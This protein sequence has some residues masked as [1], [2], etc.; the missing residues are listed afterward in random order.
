MNLYVYSDESGV[1]DKDHNKYYVF[2]GLICATKEKRDEYARLYLN[3]EKAAMLIDGIKDDREL[4]AAGISRKAKS[5]LFRSLN[6]VQKFAVVIQQERLLSNIF[7]S[8]K[9][10]QRYLDYAYKIAVKRKFE[11]LRDTGILNVNSVEHIYFCVDQHTTATDGRYEL[12]E[13][14]EQEL[15][16]GT[17]NY[18]YDTFFPPVF[19]KVTSIDLSFYDSKK[20]P[21][22]RAADIIANKVLDSA[23]NNKISLLRDERMYVIVLP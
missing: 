21:L 16:I 13:A 15:K 6:H 4:K 18:R 17:F 10:K 3:A 5:S 22:I 11:V 20:Q 19:P 12:K 8:K 2:G 1:L 14:L 7:D 23:Y 9:S